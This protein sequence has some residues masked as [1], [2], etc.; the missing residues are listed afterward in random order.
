MSAINAVA[1]ELLCADGKCGHHPQYDC[2]VHH[3]NR[4]LAAECRRLMRKAIELAVRLRVCK[5]HRRSL[6][7]SAD[8]WS[9]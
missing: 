4:V 6:Q 9:N 7:K 2:S 5:Q 8:G 3:P 1:K